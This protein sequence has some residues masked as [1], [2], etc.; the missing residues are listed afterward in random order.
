MADIDKLIQNHTLMGQELNRIKNYL[1]ENGR[2]E[3]II[4]GEGGAVPR[5]D[6]T[7]T[8]NYCVN[9]EKV[10]ELIGKLK[11]KYIKILEKSKNKLKKQIDK[12]KN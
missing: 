4:T 12:L 5:T 1:K 10:D 9:E 6:G 11:V 2:Y 3:E 7:C 8:E